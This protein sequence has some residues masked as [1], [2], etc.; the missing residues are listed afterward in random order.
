MTAFAQFLGE[1]AERYIELRHSLGYAFSKQAGTLRAFVRYVW[2]RS[3]RCAR[4]PDDGAGLRP[5]VQRRREQP[6][7]SPWRAPPV[8]RVSRRLRRPDRGL[9]AQSFP[10]IQSDSA[11]AYSQRG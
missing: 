2:A 4:Y 9:G 6:R 7:N 8:L 3:A 10:Q 5:L 1:K 11:S